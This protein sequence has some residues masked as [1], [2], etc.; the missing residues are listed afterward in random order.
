MD[1]TH[2]IFSTE[3]VVHNKYWNIEH[4]DKFWTKVHQSL[5]PSLEE[6][7][8]CWSEKIKIQ[9]HKI[10]LRQ[11]NSILTFVSFMASGQQWTC[12]IS[13]QT[14]VGPA[15]TYNIGQIILVPIM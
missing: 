7:W 1:E 9:L 15:F 3:Q 14:A 11:K 2:V 4:L 13:N 6:V 5:D 12:S 10:L 8:L